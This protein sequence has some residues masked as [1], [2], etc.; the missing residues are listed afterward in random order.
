MG[1]YTGIFSRHDKKQFVMYRLLISLY[2][3]FTDRYHQ[4][5]SL[6]VCVQFL[7]GYV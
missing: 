6:H 3:D 1:G 7:D 5:V 2:V 4:N